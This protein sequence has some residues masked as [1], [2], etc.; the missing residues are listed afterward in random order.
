MFDMEA[1][2]QLMK[3]RKATMPKDS[4]TTYLFERGRD[5][6]LKKIG[7]EATEVVIGGK[8]DD[9]DEVIYEIADLCYHIMILM[10]DMD[11]KIDDIKNELESRKIIDHKVKQEKMV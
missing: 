2:Y 9:R 3:D 11:I 7:E 10:V 8:A 1:L 5:K 6:I 4:Y